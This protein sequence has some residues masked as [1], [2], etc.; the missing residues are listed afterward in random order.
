[1]LSAQNQT[2]YDNAKK[3]AET[4]RKTRSGGRHDGLGNPVIGVDLYQKWA[5]E[6]C[7]A[8]DW[9]SA[10]HREQACPGQ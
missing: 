2:H 9:Q 4:I 1:M 8:I 5:I 6:A 7:D 3:L 10:G